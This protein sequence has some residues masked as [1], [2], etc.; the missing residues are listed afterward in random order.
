MLF[1]YRLKQFNLFTI[2]RT[3]KILKKGLHQSY[4]VI[5]NLND[6]EIKTNFEQLFK[7]LMNNYPETLLIEH[8]QELFSSSSMISE[9]LRQILIV[10]KN[11]Q[12]VQFNSWFSNWQSEFQ[13]I[14]SND[15]LVESLFLNHYILIFS[16]LSIIE[17]RKFEYITKL[18]P[19]DTTIQL[20]RMN[21]L[22]K[23]LQI[24]LFFSEVFCD[25]QLLEILYCFSKTLAE[26]EIIQGDL[27]SKIYQSLVVTT[28]RHQKGEFYTDHALV[29]IM[30]QAKYNFN[31]AVL[32][33]TC[34]SGTF[35]TEIAHGI[36]MSDASDEEKTIAFNKLVGIDCNLLACIMARAN[37]LLTLP[38]LEPEDYE[39]H[40][41]YTNALFPEENLSDKL[42]KQFDL[43]IGNPP[44]LVLNRIPD[45]DEQ[46]RIKR[47][48]NQFGILLGGKLATTTEETTIFIYHSLK[49]YLKTD[50]TIFFVVPASLA[51][52][53][54]HELF[55]QFCGMHEIGFW[56]FDKDVF[57]IHNLCFYAQK[58][59]IQIKERLHIHW[60]QYHCQLN[61]LRL[62]IISEEIFI[63]ST[64]TLVL[65]K[66][67]KLLQNQFRIGRLIA[68]THPME[69]I[70][71]LFQ[72]NLSLI[73]PK[74]KTVKQHSGSIYH[75]LFRQGAS[76]VPRNLIFIDQFK[77]DSADSHIV[78]ISPDRSI[79]SKKYSTWEFQA[80]AEKTIESDYV[81]SVA[82]STGLFPFMYA[83][84][85]SVFLPLE[86]DS[87]TQQY[88]VKEPVP[89]IGSKP[90]SNPSKNLSRE[91]KIW[92]RNR[93][94]GKTVRLRPCSFATRTI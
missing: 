66:K 30:V 25:S 13:K 49:H 91:Y 71:K 24:P 94:V 64:I 65:D 48:G 2:T 33:P 82:K 31:E 56:A 89:T 28:Q 72:L 85:Y 8:I 88:I 67:R 74:N 27:F 60:I 93:N 53:A 32:D 11:N 9:S 21:Y 55:R 92:C 43:V 59:N 61:P 57:R 45:K 37:L 77:P 18:N 69:D 44:W 79:R 58:G 42:D 5:E 26:K 10:I 36:F 38:N 76:L 81:F 35:L 78:S 75:A 3:I 47:Y 17:S 4:N 12:P 83:I 50:G 19:K 80:Y 1:I 41:Y 46:N 54:Q 51:T 63:P 40:I 84:P 90:L 62:N 86:Y 20:S 6:L 68:S 23:Q 29:K 14:Y 52:G 34:G 15:E 39:L 22:V 16:I 73:N 70:A 87:T 7:D